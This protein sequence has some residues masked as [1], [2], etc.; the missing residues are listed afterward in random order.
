MR[1]LFVII[2]FLFALTLSA[3]T[4]S[5][6]DMS[7]GGYGIIKTNMAVSYDQGWGA[8]QDGFAAR[9]SY[10]FM[11]TKKWTVTANAHYTSAE[12]SFDADDLD[13][14][15]KPN[16]INLNGTHLFGQIGATTT[17]KTHVFG[18][19]F[20]AMSMINSEW[21]QGGFARVSGIAMGLLML[22]SNRNTQFGLGPMVMANTCSKLPAFLIFMYRHRF[23]EKWLLNLYGGMF[24]MDYNPNKR[25]LIS[26]GADVD[27]KAFYFK[28]N[29]ENLPEKCRFTSTSFR[30]MARFRHRLADNLYFDMQGGVMLKMSSRVNG[31]TGSKEWINCNQK[32][33]LFLQAGV[34]W[35]I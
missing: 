17:F 7:R 13:N 23:N 16:E 5:D 21:S 3:Q 9:V 19:L 4:E 10:E 14:G 18:K 35:G 20:M 15:F 30:P 31:T 28:P 22:R 29:N 27:V 1:K 25:N 32:A 24:G 11:R 12:V 33:A 8:I 26:I 34:S 2:T 6:V